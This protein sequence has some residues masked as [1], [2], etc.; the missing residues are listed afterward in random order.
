MKALKAAYR[1]D[2]LADADRQAFEALIDAEPKVR[3]WL[4]G[5]FKNL[6]CLSLLRQGETERAPS[7]APGRPSGISKTAATFTA[8]PS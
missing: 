7:C 2:Y 6:L 4:R 5:F 1:G 3:V 8:A